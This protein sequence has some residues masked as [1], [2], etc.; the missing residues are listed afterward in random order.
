MIVKSSYTLSQKNISVPPRHIYR[1]KLIQKAIQ[2]IRR[3]RFRV[4]YHEN[5]HQKSE[6]RDFFGLKSESKPPEVTS[7][8][9]FE[10]AFW[11]MIK[12]VKFRRDVIERR[13]P[14]QRDLK[15]KISD[16]TKNDKSVI[17]KGDKSS[18]LYHCP[19]NK[20]DDLVVTNLRKFYKKEDKNRPKIVQKINE[21]IEKF[22]EIYNV[23]DRIRYVKKQDVFLTLKDHKDDFERT[24]PCRLINPTKSDLG[25]ISKTIL[26]KV[27]KDVRS[28]FK[29]KLGQFKNTNEAIEWFRTLQ[30]CERK[31]FLTYDICD[32]YPSISEPILTKALLWAKEHVKSGILNQNNIDLILAARISILAY[33]G[34]IWVKK[35]GE[36]DVTMGS[37]DGAEVSELVGLY[38]LYELGLQ[39]IIP[40]GTYGLYRDDG[41]V[42]LTTSSGR[43]QEHIRQ[44]LRKFFNNRGFKIDISPARPFVDYLDVRMHIDK[45]HEI[46]YKPN[47]D[48]TYVNIQS[49]HPNSILKNFKN[50]TENRLST[51]CS[52][53]QLFERHAQ[54]YKDILSKS[55]HPSDISFKSHN[56][57]EN[58]KTRKRKNRTVSWFNPPFNL[59]VKSNLGHQFFDLIGV[60]FGKS[61]PLKFLN[62]HTVKLSYSTMGNV[63]SI[64]SSHNKKV[65]SNEAKTS[66]TC[67]CNSQY[68]GEPRICTIPTLCN[69]TNVVYKAK[70]TE[71]ARNKKSVYFGLTMN[72]LKTR[73]N[74]HLTSF[75]K[76]SNKTAT[77]I[78]NCIHDIEDRG[79]AYEI[80]WSVE[81]RTKHWN[82][83]ASCNLCLA[84]KSSILF[85]Q[86]RNVLN[87]RKELFSKCPHQKKFQIRKKK[88]NQN[89]ENEEDDEEEYF[90]DAPSNPIPPDTDTT[91]P[92]EG[93]QNDEMPEETTNQPEHDHQNR[94]DYLQ[95][96]QNWHDANMNANN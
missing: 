72:P 1:E 69:E 96:R 77:T 7:L 65:L 2:F 60:H 85:S 21:K 82:G 38:L 8:I 27:L 95:A 39:G 53:R 50:N 13:N 59:D 4:Y 36:F 9:P 51:L 40:R 3:L 25:T 44:D 93:D 22:G 35:T 14:F 73:V 54:R 81:R 83:G 79:A 49:N 74:Q 63:K 84:E 52:N 42:A 37:S 88:K 16:L 34:D 87:Q 68:A 11:A 48:T 75:K 70:V 28:I 23:V 33:K 30:D 92:T 31:A 20:Y 10:T 62:K 57:P 45:T 46:Y 58:R 86:D 66:G 78:A 26:D 15:S 43:R 94:F 80:D 89:G 5:P 90:Y 12:N 19:V 61:G 32:F 41:I 29:P 18:Y 56:Q 64:Y 17:I 71:T 91:E 6:K 55:G 24:E 47:N 67:K 76:R